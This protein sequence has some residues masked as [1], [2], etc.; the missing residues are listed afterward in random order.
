[1]ADARGG[2]PAALSADG[3]HPNAAGYALMAPLADAAIA[4]ALQRR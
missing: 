3:V 1:M 4:A 2:L